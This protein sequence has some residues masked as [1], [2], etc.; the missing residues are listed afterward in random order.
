MQLGRFVEL[1]ETFG[2][3]LSGRVRT[4]DSPRQG[5]VIP[6]A[7]IVGPGTSSQDSLIDIPHVDREG[8]ALDPR[9][10]KVLEDRCSRRMCDPPL[11]DLP[12][13]RNIGLGNESQSVQRLQFRLQSRV[14]VELRGSDRSPS[15][16]RLVQL[17]SSPYRV[18]RTSFGPC[19][20]S[21]RLP[22]PY[23]FR[24]WCRCSPCRS[25]GWSF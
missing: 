9:L 13:S 1:G 14:L 20:P 17:S 24:F 12:G 23:A 8:R 15:G 22:C 10:L 11:Q 25:P 7:V 21:S 4:A 16:L 5:V 19:T 3:E 18:D 2:E 6:L